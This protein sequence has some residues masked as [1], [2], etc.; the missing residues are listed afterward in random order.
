MKE[1]EELSSPVFWSEL[2][3]TLEEIKPQESKLPRGNAKREKIGDSSKSVVEKIETLER[4]Y[5]SGQ[6]WNVG[7]IDSKSNS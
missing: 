6:V 7:S 5:E 4:L 2:S 1:T 3:A